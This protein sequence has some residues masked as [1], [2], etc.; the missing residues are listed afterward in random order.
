MNVAPRRI[1]AAMILVI[2]TGATHLWAQDELPAGARVIAEGLKFP[3]GPAIDLQGN[4]VFSDVWG[5]KIY[6]W[7]GTSASVLIDPSGGANGLALDPSGNIFACAGAEA[8]IL[9]YAP[10]GEKTVLLKEVGGKPLN[11][12]NDLVFD[13]VGNLYF[14]NPAGFSGAKEGHSPVSVV[15]LRP[16]GSASIV[17]SGELA[18]P[19]G[20]GLS[21]D[22]KTLYVN[23]FLGG[24][25]VFKFEVKEDG[26]LGPAE[27]FVD[28]GAGGP[29]G[30]AVAA[31][32]NLYVALNLKAR[33]M[34]VT[35]DGQFSEFLVFPKGSGVTNVCFG[36]TDMK[37]LFVTLA[38]KGKVVTFDIDEPGLKL[39]GNR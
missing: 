31:S 39:Y 14:T 20:I 22:G 11:A 5:T 25:K 17:S 15:L 36:G 13:A 12:P 38:G 7:D 1:F 29:D 27:L 21:P 4:L 23:D 37:T 9:R 28:F 32:G 16:D 34:K 26:A 33:V 3:E 35:P 18:Y 8:A 19:N 30:M 10:S 24:S 6:R 2:L